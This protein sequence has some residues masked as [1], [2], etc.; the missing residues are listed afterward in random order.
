MINNLHNI[1]SQW[2]PENVQS[3]KS[4]EDS[5]EI[6]SNFVQLVNPEAIDL[7]KLY[8]TSNKEIKAELVKIYLQN[9]QYS[10][11]MATTDPTIKDKI[12]SVYKALNLPVPDEKANVGIADV[13]SQ[14]H[15]FCAKQFKQ[16]KGLSSAIK[17]AY[18]I[19]SQ[20]DI[21]KVDKSGAIYTEQEFSIKEGTPSNPQEL[22]M[23][24]VEGALFK[25]IYENAIKPIVHPLGWGYIYYRIV[26]MFF[27]D[28]FNISIGYSD[29]VIEVRC[30]GNKITSFTEEPVENISE[31][32]DGMRTKKIVQFKNGNF[33]IKDFNNSVTLYDADMVKIKAYPR[34]CVLYLRYNTVI[35]LT[36]YDYFDI[37]S[38]YNWLDYYNHEKQDCNH[39]IGMNNLAIG[40]GSAVTVGNEYTIG[41]NIFAFGG[42]IR[43]DGYIYDWNIGCIKIHDVTDTMF[44]EVDILLP[45]SKVCTKK[46]DNYTIGEFILGSGVYI[47]DVYQRDVRADVFNLKTELHES[48]TFETIKLVYIGG[49]VIGDG[50]LIGSPEPITYL[51]Y[52]PIDD[53]STCAG[54]RDENVLYT[55]MDVIYKDLVVLYNVDDCSSK[56]IKI[57]IPTVLYDGEL[58]TDDGI[59]VTYT[60]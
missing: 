46:N 35:T 15:L 11:E 54:K 14:E 25:E 51:D 27:V 45:Y 42:T 55:N 26:P 28:Y 17:Y 53:C 16:S 50:T 33:L 32:V 4:V 59:T 9:L 39:R 40:S 30:S 37:Q 12:K 24:T 60:I 20:T 44:Q 6:F 8:S 23:F 52:R 29:V 34:S 22:F 10:F 36:T 58:V 43:K 47:G 1:M 2:V 13:I 49:F 7:S 57:N 38:E 56:E 18:N 41:S 19:L 31:I 21:Q 5:I 3:N 48:L